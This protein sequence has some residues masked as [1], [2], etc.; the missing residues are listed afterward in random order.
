M[1]VLFILTLLGLAGCNF[2]HS[3]SVIFVLFLVDKI[4]YKQTKFCVML[5]L[6]HNLLIILEQI[7][8]FK[9]NI[10]VGLTV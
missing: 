7:C 9:T 4:T 1:C 8:S 5:K 6:F 2:W 10:T 3:L